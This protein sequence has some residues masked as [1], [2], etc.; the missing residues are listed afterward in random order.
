ML[1]CDREYSEVEYSQLTKYQRDTAINLMT[2]DARKWWW[3]RDVFYVEDEGLD[4][5][6]AK[7]LVVS[8]EEKRKSGLT[9]LSKFTTV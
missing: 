2:S 6:H 5:I 1:A 8:A 7:A 4:D 9:K 3:F